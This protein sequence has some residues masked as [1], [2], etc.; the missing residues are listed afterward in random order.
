MYTQHPSGLL[1]PT[2]HK[3]NRTAF[4]FFAGAGGMSVGLIKSGFEVVGGLEWGF[5]AAHTYLANLGAW[6]MNLHFTS[7]KYR[8]RFNTYLEK[9]VFKDTEKRG[10]LDLRTGI[11]SDPE[12][13]REYGLP[14]SGWIA[15]ERMVGNIHNPVRNFWIG[16]IR[17]ATGENILRTLGMQRGELDVV[18]GGPPC[19]G[20]ST[21]NTSKRKGDWDPR[22]DL[23]FQYARMIV[24]LAP[25][26]F[27]M[28]EVP[29]ILDYYTPHGVPVIEQFIRILD[30][31][32]Y[33]D[34]Q[35]L[36]EA[37]NYAP[38][39]SR[40]VYRNPSRKHDT[41]RDK[42]PAAAQIQPLQ[43]SLF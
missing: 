11:E 8:E 34:F 39:G 31:G 20:Y 28:E 6:P 26:T 14:G 12:K 40:V 9:K 35:A 4:D 16:D 19:Q 24:E 5:D 1:L 36:C 30:E 25:K 27:V 37:M 13:I 7:D 3:P 22:N 41:Q 2:R 10:V 15:N 43:T 32:G 17:E 18:C 42:N 33:G 29:A 38:K 21:A 23:V